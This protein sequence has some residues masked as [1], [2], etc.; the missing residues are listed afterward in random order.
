MS[1][2]KFATVQVPQSPLHNGI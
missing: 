2:R 1:E